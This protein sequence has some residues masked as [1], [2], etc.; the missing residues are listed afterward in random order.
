VCFKPLMLCSLICVSSP[1]V[2]LCWF[3]LVRRLNWKSIWPVKCFASK[4][5]VQIKVK[6]SWP[7]IP[8]AIT[9]YKMTNKMLLLLVFLEFCFLLLLFSSS[10][11]AT[12]SNSIGDVTKQFKVALNS[13]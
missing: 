8:I 3:N 4:P 10:K 11:L 7:N 2:C 13:V 1:E 6:T 12:T 9:F 5:L